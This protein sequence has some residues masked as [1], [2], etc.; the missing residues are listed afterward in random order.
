MNAITNTNPEQLII[1][2]IVDHVSRN[3]VDVEWHICQSDTL[4]GDYLLEQIKAF[5]YQSELAYQLVFPLVDQILEYVRSLLFR[6]SFNFGDDHFLLV[7]RYIRS[8]I[9]ALNN[10]S[11]LLGAA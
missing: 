1:G 8:E 2:V 4:T 6:A 3:L 5:V 10:Q 9:S 11:T 7:L